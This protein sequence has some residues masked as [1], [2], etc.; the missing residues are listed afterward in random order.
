MDVVVLSAEEEADA[1]F[2]N[3]V[4]HGAEVIDERARLHRHLRLFNHRFRLHRALSVH[5]GPSIA[6]T[7]GASRALGKC[8]PKADTAITGRLSKATRAR[9]TSGPAN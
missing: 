1:V 3:L 9:W 2:V 8:T 4:L 7:C 5:E 6:R